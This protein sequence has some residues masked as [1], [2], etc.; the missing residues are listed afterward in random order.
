MPSLRE[1]EDFKIGRFWDEISQ[2]IN[3]RLNMIKY[4]LSDPNKTKD[5]ADVRGLQSESMTCNWLL[6]LPD[7]IIDELNEIRNK[8]EQKDG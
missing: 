1:W 3:D 5:L 7:M 4:D 2:T 6:S 8:K